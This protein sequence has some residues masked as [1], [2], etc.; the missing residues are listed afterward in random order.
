MIKILQKDDH[1][2]V[3]TRTKPEVL[4]VLSGIG[5]DVHIHTDNMDFDTFLQGK[6]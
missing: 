3:L 2:V 1:K 5:C 6:L 4:P